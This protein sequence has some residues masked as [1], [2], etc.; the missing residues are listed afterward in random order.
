LKE[1]AINFGIHNKSDMT[2]M[3]F[4]RLQRGVSRY[5]QV[6]NGPFSLENTQEAKSKTTKPTGH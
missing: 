1:C 3:H 5:G 6:H 4:I 2:P